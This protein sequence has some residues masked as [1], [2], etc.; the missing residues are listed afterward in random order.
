MLL[1]VSLISSVIVGVIGFVNGRESLRAAAFEQL[2][3]IRDLRAEA[4][5]R[6]I[7]SLQQGVRLDSR[8]AS[9]VQA[10][11]AFVSGFQQLNEGSVSEGD[12]ESVREF[13]ESSF[14][15][16]LEARSGLDYEP[17]AFVPATPAGIYLQ[18]RY[19][20]NRA[21]DDYDAGLALDDAGDGSAWSAA[22]A[23]Y[24]DYFTGLV[25]ELGYED[26]LVLDKSA[27]VVFSAYKS[28]DLGVNMREEPYGETALTQAFD[29]VMRNGSLDEVMTTDFERYLPSL[30]VPTAWV[31]S[32]VGKATDIVGAIAVQIPVE[33]INSVMTGDSQWASQ[34]LGDTGEVY[35]AGKDLLMRSVSRLLIQDP[36]SYVDAVV[37][38]GTSPDVAKR[39]V[40]VNGT[41]QLQPVDF[42]GV[43]RA[44][45]GRTG[46]VV[47]GDYT[48]SNSLVAYAP[49]DIEG[50]DWVIVAHIDADEAF[51]PVTEFTRNLVLST[52]AI[53]LAVSIASLL[54]AQ[55]FA[56][57]VRRLVDAVHRIAGGDLTVQV[58]QGNRDEFGDLGMAFND[59]AA[60]LRI[61]QD[62]IEAQREENQKL[63][64]TLMPSTVA[65]RYK[66]GEESIS[67]EHENVSV[68]Y[69]EL[70]GFDDFAASLTG[71]QEITQLN[72]LMRGFDEAAQAAGVEKVRTLRGGYLASSGL[73]VPRVD[74]VRRAVDFANDMRQVVQ[75]F[76]S[77]HGT[78]IDLRAGVDTGTVTSGLVARTTLAY[79]L[80][81]DAVSL[82][83]RV[84]SVTDTPGVYVS[85]AVRDRLQDSVGFEE[86]GTV[87]LN[88]STQIVWRL[89]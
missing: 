53:L 78:S 55:V 19:V 18:A 45:S 82:A 61:K 22:N 36:A 83:Y 37:A 31:I 30:N 10:A 13:Y 38:T 76:N 47:A 73:I 50:L 89:A 80:W 74:N 20:A 79:D 71:E 6:E 26:V 41:V 24:G 2:T 88:G 77:Q 48:N 87:D 21:Y 64:L 14:V 52:L 60:G 27:N 54:L 3:S 85:Q 66:K 57:P 39:I 44:I 49:V 33:Q 9:A 23:E 46:T 86:A 67:E 8:N 62:L 7:G 58:P 11:E 70:I 15:P 12:R 17:E 29:A 40:Q 42:A 16:A 68:V 72:V 28:V 25:D 51:Q 56:R 5:E 43:R 32:P 81:G 69:A 59:M 84:R 1:L 75:R 34:G 35:L 4:I 65:E 63:L